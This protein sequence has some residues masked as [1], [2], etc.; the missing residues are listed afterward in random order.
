LVAADGAR[1][2]PDLAAQAA[3]GASSS[4]ALLHAGE[5]TVQTWIFDVPKGAKLELAI[6]WGGEWLDR[7]DWLVLGERRIVL[8]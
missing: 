3:L 2:E 5:S 6:S 4:R 7:L 8:P 1:Y